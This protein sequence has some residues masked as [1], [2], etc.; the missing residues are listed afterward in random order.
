MLLAEGF[1]ALCIIR[2]NMVSRFY[3]NCNFYMM[4]QRIANHDINLIFVIK[5]TPITQDLILTQSI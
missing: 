3:L 1:Q 4:S 5:C 2:S